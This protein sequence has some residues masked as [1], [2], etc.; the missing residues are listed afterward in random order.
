MAE[1]LQEGKCQKEITQS[2]QWYEETDK[3]FTYLKVVVNYE[4]SINKKT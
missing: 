4:K 3:G 2:K 1:S